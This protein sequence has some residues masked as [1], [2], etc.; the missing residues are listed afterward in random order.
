V[1]I[2]AITVASW[3]ICDVAVVNDLRGNSITRHALEPGASIK[4]AI[5]V[6]DVSGGKVTV[7]QGR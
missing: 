1:F 4:N 7:V 6:T 2:A 3:S 5:A